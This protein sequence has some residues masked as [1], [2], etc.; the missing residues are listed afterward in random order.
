MYVITS[1]P[2][3]HRG[4]PDSQVM[5]WANVTI[6]LCWF[7]IIMSS[8]W[9]V[10]MCFNRCKQYYALRMLCLLSMEVDAK[11]FVSTIQVTVP[12]RFPAVLHCGT[13]STPTL[14]WHKPVGANRIRIFNGIDIA[15]N[16]SH[17][18]S[19]KNSTN[20]SYTSYDLF[21]RSTTRAEA[22]R[23][24]C[25]DSQTSD[26]LRVFLTLTGR[27]I[28]KSHEIFVQLQTLSSFVSASLNSLLSILS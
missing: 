23:Y 6:Q 28:N 18:Y 9:F 25:M 4:H 15:A 27:T 19:M 14:L 21:I 5:Q 20:G 2:K 8:I 24:D 7:S 22:G 26:A 3:L 16:Y 1:E 12:I 10:Y 17:I 11:V 13:D